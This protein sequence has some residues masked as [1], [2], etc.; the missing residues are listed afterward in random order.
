M[1]KLAHGAGI[2]LDKLEVA[3]AIAYGE[4][5]FNERAFNGR[6]PDLSYGLWQI[7]MLDKPGYQMGAQR[8]ARWGLKSNDEL[9]TPAVNARAMADISNKGANWQPWSVYTNGS[10][11]SGGGMALAKPAVAQLRA[12]LGGGATTQARLDAAMVW[13]KAQVGKPYVLGAFGAQFDCSTYMSGIA[14]MIRD[15]KA[16]RW[17]TTHPFHSGA[18]NP[19]PG[20][21]RDLEAP[22]M[23][24]IDASGIGHTGG[25]LMGVEFEA[26]AAGNRVVRMGP[27]AR[28]ARDP[29]YQYVY[30][31]RPSLVPGFPTTPA[32]R[33]VASM[34]AAI[35]GLGYMPALDVDGVLGPLTMAGIR[36]LQEKVGTIVDGDWG[37]VTEAAYVAYKPPVIPPMPTAP[38]TV[39]AMQTAINGLGYQPALAVDGVL[40]T[41]TRAG[42]RWLQSRVGTI[43]DGEWGPVTEAAYLRYV[44]LP[45]APAPGEPPANYS[46]TTYGGRT[47]NMRTRLMLEDAQRR[48]GWS[49][50]VLT[51]G[52][53][54]RGVG[55]SAGTH[56]GGGVVDISVSAWSSA[57]RSKAL[58]ALRQAGFFAWLRTPA[59]NFSYHIHAVAIGDRE[60][61]SAAKGQVSQGFADRN[62]LAGRGPDP[63][64]DPYPAWASRYGRHVSP[65]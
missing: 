46:R 21:E 49:G 26:T 37:P 50:F 43:V 53:Y 56:D 57:Q 34:Q 15:G 40:G 2:P 20:W 7:N 13:A 6:D 35:N 27:G 10:Y 25:T 4:S 44:K 64:P 8:R 52:S 33:S 55:A 58:Y 23:I 41:Y 31:F 24:G 11:V 30:G 54:N 32:P 38:R 51:Q 19:L 48:L 12:E 16:A 39:S 45:T 29:M 60:M 3:V 59:Q 63:D 28:G 18:K 9:F 62:G 65:D 61:S 42:I 14:T 47:V 36:W 1:A 17:F 5:R 22:F